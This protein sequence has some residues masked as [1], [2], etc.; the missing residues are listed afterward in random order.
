[1]DLG[2]SRAIPVDIALR[3]CGRIISSIAEVISY[4]IE[5]EVALVGMVAVGRI[6]LH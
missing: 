1:M 3:L 4:P 2:T 6:C 5:P